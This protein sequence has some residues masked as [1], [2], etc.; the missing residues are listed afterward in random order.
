LARLQAEAIRPEE[1]VAE[2]RRDVDGAVA[3]FLG[4]VRDHH[5]G[6]RV[7][8]LDYH[9]Y[10]GMA[11]REMER[12]EAAARERFGVSR[13]AVVHR[14]GRLE[15]GEVSVAVAVAAPHRAEAMEACRFVID[16]LKQT[17]PIWKKEYYEDGAVWIDGAGGVP[18]PG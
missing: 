3:L 12:I 15:I 8:H 10:P 13:V 6:R 4:T 18:S 11:E 2:V 17:V 9:A 1:L 7:R 14:T 16:R 5:A